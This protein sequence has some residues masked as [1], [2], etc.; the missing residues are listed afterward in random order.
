D[1][2]IGQPART[3]R[4]V[5]FGGHRRMVGAAIFRI[6][7]EARIAGDLPCTAGAVLLPF[8]LAARCRRDRRLDLR[9]H[10]RVGSVGNVAIGGARSMTAAPT[11]ERLAP[12]KLGIILRVGLFII[13]GWLTLIISATMM[14][15][16]M[17]QREAYFVISAL[18]VFTAAAVANAVTVRIYE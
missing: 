5:R 9:R 15:W 3:H 11:P 4:I 14:V 6:G 10:R 2:R 13:L 1:A 16:L 12:D 7:R 17:G 8:V 18:S